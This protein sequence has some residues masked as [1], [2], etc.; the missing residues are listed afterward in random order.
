M[1]WRMLID[2]EWLWYSVMKAH[3]EEEGVVEGGREV[4][5]CM[6]EGYGGYS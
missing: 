6:V 4:W 3:Y 1:V 2:K 5:F